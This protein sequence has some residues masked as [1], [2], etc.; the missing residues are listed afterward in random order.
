MKSLRRKINRLVH[1]S[2]MSEKIHRSAENSIVKDLLLNC[3]M[4]LN[5]QGVKPVKDQIFFELQQEEDR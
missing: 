1:W 2:I 3:E 5:N 4:W